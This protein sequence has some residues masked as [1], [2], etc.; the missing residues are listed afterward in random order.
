MKDWKEAI[1]Y[2]IKHK[3]GFSDDEVLAFLIEKYMEGLN[4]TDSYSTDL[5]ESASDI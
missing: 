5:V 4:D 2:K 3:Y 1:L